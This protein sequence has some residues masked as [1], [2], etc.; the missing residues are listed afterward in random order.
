MLVRVFETLAK[1][2]GLQK[3]DKP[4]SHMPLRVKIQGEALSD[5]FLGH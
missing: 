4:S 5:P 2:V 1:P 3:S